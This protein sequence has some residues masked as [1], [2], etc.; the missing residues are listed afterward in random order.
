MPVTTE[1]A[2]RAVAA[3]DTRFDGCFVTAVRTTGIYCR[4]SCPARTPKPANLEFFPTT[5]A[6]QSAGYRACRRCLPDAVPGSPEWDLRAD[7]AGRAMRLINDGLVERAG[8]VGLAAALGYSTRHLTRVLTT[9]LGAGPLAL[10][11]AHRAHSAR[12]LIE[13]SELAFTDIAF[14]TGF[15]S[16]RQFNATVREVFATTPTVLR[17]QARRGAGPREAA[18]GTI[19]LRLPL[20]PPL[21]VEGLLDFLA[22]RAVAGVEEAG[23]EHYSRALRLPHGAGVVTVRPEGDHLSATL[24]LTDLRDLGSAVARIRRLFDLDADPAAVTEVLGSDPA[25]ATAVARTPGIRVPGSV[26]GTEAVIRAVLGQQVSVPAARTTAGRLTAALGDP[27][28]RPDNRMSPAVTTLFPSAEALATTEAAH[29]GGPRRRVEAV[30]S[31][32]AALA[33][34]SL[35]IHPGRD[36]RELRRELESFPGIGPWTAR[37]VSMRVLGAPDVLLTDDLALRRG[38]AALGIP[39]ARAPLRARAARWS[40]W[41]SYAGMHLWRAAARSPRKRTRHSL[42]GREHNHH[43]T[44]ES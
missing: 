19:R 21:D 6:A 33:D 11:R 30:R 17:D 2:H 31:V 10:A 41:C 37:Y 12:T 28:A 3:R 1:Q 24:R 5:A 35:E 43:S 22:N 4:P 18:A 25:L 36:E 34:G 38:A 7:L 13:T 27:L 9:E 26:D 23:P 8:V 20:R 15:A 40:P 39:T 14:A 32:A 44:R 42:H 29:I 16:L